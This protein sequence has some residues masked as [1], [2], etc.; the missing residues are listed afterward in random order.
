MK[1]EITSTDRRLLY[2][3]SLSP[4]GEVYYIE[5]GNAIAA[6]QKG[7]GHAALDDVEWSG[8]HVDLASENETTDYYGD[9]EE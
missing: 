6:Q 3:V 4:G 8:M 7:I 2:R 1:D 9:E 5:A